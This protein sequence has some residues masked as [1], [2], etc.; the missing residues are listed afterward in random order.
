MIFN[1]IC[2]NNYEGLFCE[3][4][5]E[6]KNITCLNNG[7]CVADFTNETCLCPS[8]YSGTYCETKDSDLTVLENVSASISVVGVIS[9]SC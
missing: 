8:Y 7:N 2:Q 1:C 6:C 3:I 9:L 5:N 4:N